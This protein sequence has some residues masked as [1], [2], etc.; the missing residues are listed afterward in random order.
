M[1][2]AYQNSQNTSLTKINECLA[3]RDQPYQPE[4]NSFV[5][6]GAAFTM[7]SFPMSRLLAAS[8]SGSAVK[9]TGHAK[10]H[11]D[12]LRSLAKNNAL[13]PQSARTFRHLKTVADACKNI[14][15]G[16]KLAKESVGLGPEE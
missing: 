7:T 5:V 6:L 14:R 2:E 15:I 9:A 8:T 11:I 10:H 13:S 12:P 16:F 4:Y 1:A 3:T